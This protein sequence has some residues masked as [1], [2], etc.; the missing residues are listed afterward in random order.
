[1]ALLLHIPLQSCLINANNYQ[2]CT[3]I[4][5][6][7]S[8]NKI[9]RRSLHAFTFNKRISKFCDNKMIKIL[10]TGRHRPGGVHGDPDGRHRG[11]RHVQGGDQ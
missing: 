9:Q 8:T 10:M 7:I 3:N 5:L 1:M 4:F 6:H 11:C 2:S